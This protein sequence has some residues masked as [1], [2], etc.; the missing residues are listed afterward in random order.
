MTLC[1]AWRSWR[2]THN[3]WAN[4]WQLWKPRPVSGPRSAVSGCVLS[5]GAAPWMSGLRWNWMTPAE[6]AVGR[7]WLELHGAEFEEV[8]VQ[9]E[10][11]HYDALAEMRVRLQADPATY[12]AWRR[13]T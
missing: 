10:V 9:H 4:G 12:L 11:G 2:N 1:R 7:A 3:A 8:Q 5:M 6:S 13:A